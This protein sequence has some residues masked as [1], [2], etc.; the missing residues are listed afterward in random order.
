MMN[1]KTRLKFY[2]SAT[3]ILGRYSKAGKVWHKKMKQVIK[4]HETH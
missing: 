1:A 3:Y 4:N 2:R